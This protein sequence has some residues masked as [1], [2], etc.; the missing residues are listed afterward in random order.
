MATDG[1]RRNLVVVSARNSSL[2]SQTFA[3]VP[4]HSLAFAA[5]LRQEPIGSENCPFRRY[6]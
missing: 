2:S 6:P 3:I 1:L 4:P 5:P